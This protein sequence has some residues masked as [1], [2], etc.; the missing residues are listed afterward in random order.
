MK[1]FYDKIIVNGDSYSALK[2]NFA[3]STELEQLLNVSVTNIAQPGSNN[4]RIARTTIEQVL[5]ELPNSK[6]I[7]VIVGWS[8]VRRIEVWYYGNS[9][10][11]INRIPDRNHQPE[12]NNPHF[13][14]LDVL[15]SL[16]ELTIEQKCLINEDLFVH[17]QLT[18]FY[19]NVYLVSQFLQNH[20]VDYL[21]F[22][23]AKNV[24][25]PVNSFPYISNLGQ[26]KQVLADPRIL[27][28]HSFYI[29]DWAKHN[30]TQAHPVT[31]HLSRDGHSKFAKLLEEKI[32]DLQSH[33]ATQSRR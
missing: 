8:F 18:D 32:N 19:S 22:S 4:D 31:G 24:E 15:A 29:Q 26:V 17:K 30:D 1:N 23:A 27:D 2:D 28:L 6:K 7:L 25:I 21:F 10:K 12:C 9:I 13:V 3:Y 5:Q 16:N 14:T 33:Q 20:H 11:V